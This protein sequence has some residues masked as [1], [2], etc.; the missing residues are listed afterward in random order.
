MIQY[1]NIK[2][3][4]Q[5]WSP[6]GRYPMV[7]N[8]QFE[9]YQEALTFATTN[10]VAV[11]GSVITVTNDPDTTKRGVYELIYTGE[12]P[13]TKDTQP[14]GIKRV[15][16]DIDLSNYVTKDQITNVYKAKGSKATFAELPVVDATVGDVWNVEEAHG[17]YP[18]GTNWVWTGTEWDALSGITDLSAYALKADVDKSLETIEGNIAT[19]TGAIGTINNTLANKVDAVT[20]YSLISEEKLQLIDTSAGQIGQLVAADESLTG[21]V[22]ALEGLFKDSGSGG[23][24][25]LG[26]INSQI[27]DHGTRLTS[28]ESDNTANKTA[29]GQLNEFK[30]SVSTQLEAIVELNTQQTGQI[31]GLTTELGNV[32]NSVSTHTT[33]IATLNTAVGTNTQAI[34]EIKNSINGLAIKSVSSS[35]KVLAAD[36]NGVLSTTINLDHY[37]DE[38]DGKTYVALTGIEGAVIS[39][40]DASDFV[41]DSFV[42]TVVYDPATKNMTITWNTES[43]KQPTVIPM[44]GLVDTYTAG[45]GL[46][47]ANNEF[48]VV[49]SKN[50]NNKLTVTN[51]GLLVDISEDLTALETKLNG[52]IASAF[53]WVNVE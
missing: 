22:E 47:V 26:T 3:Y 37:K 34:G 16:A 36:T 11:V 15:G 12:A 13:L 40:F 9:T 38:T 43:G 7:D 2:A 53:E 17:G 6:M 51:D 31:T 20:G 46:T 32:K 5:V 50:E 27:S 19:N 30:T 35:E 41:K 39:R 4:N 24:I 28:L 21:R 18:A 8:S 45:T 42:D 29:I 25:D 48:S 49:L 10:A 33:E 52:N 1:S 44:S 14:T 23:T